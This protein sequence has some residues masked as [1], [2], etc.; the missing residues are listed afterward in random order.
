MA[1]D[2]DEKD[3]CANPYETNR[4]YLRILTSLQMK[5]LKGM[6]WI[7]EET[8]IHDGLGLLFVPSAEPC[9]MSARS[10]SIRNSINHFISELHENIMGL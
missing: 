9:K 8:Y 2:L 5:A 10:I 6:R 1:L 4:D 7:K 3:N